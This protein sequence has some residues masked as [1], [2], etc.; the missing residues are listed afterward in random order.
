MLLETR[1]LGVLG[2]YHTLC[3]WVSSHAQQLSHSSIGSLI[4]SSSA[5][6][7]S[8]RHVT[9][10]KK[11]LSTNSSHAELLACAL[12]LDYFICHFWISA[13]AGKA[14]LIHTDNQAIAQLV[15][16]NRGFSL[17]QN[18]LIV[19]FSSLQRSIG[20]K[21]YIHWIPRRLNSTSDKLSKEKLQS[22]RWHNG[23]ASKVSQHIPSRK[24]KEV[25]R[26]ILHDPI[27]LQVSFPPLF[28]FSNLFLV[29]VSPLTLPCFLI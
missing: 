18:K 9:E 20:F 22:I 28:P 10:F 29:F 21:L 3:T 6:F 19:Y 15:N 5:S 26:S 17:P 2:F 7:H 8:R 12:S 4:F 27:Y 11:F 1:V 14:L 16:G 24:L 13:L 23:F 25:L